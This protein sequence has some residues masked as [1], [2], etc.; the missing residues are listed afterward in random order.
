[1]RA[2]EHLRHQA[3]AGVHVDQRLP[4]AHVYRMDC[5]QAHGD[6][7]GHVRGHEARPVGVSAGSEIA[8][9]VGFVVMTEFQHGGASHIADSLWRFDVG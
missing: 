5:G 1:M 4:A 7:S 6:G 3:A 9:L 2:H 8:Q